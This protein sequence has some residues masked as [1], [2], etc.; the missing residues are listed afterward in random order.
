[1]AGVCSCS[2]REEETTSLRETERN[3][4]CKCKIIMA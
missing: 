1:M 3:T 4:G 2:E